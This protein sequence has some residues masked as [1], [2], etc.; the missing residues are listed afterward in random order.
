[1][2]AYRYIGSIV[3]ALSSQ[4]SK[5]KNG[6]LMPVYGNYGSYGGKK[7]GGKSGKKFSSAMYTKEEKRLLEKLGI[8][9]ED[10]QSLLWLGGGGLMSMYGSGGGGAVPMGAYSMPSP[11]QGG[12]PRYGNRGMTGMPAGYGMTPTSPAHAPA[13]QQM[14]GYGTPFQ[15]SM[16]YTAPDGTTYNISSTGPYDK[17]GKS[18][19]TAMG[20]YNMI[21]AK[22]GGKGGGKGGKGASY[23]GGKGGK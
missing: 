7:A 4:V 13:V 19:D 12:M 14:Q 18:I 10:P 16:Q 1:L 5:M 15:I 20:L 9:P 3:A 23:S 21:D 11:M 17:R 2:N 6:N 8:D 22:Y